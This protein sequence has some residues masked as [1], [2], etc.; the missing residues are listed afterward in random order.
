MLLVVHAGDAFGEPGARRA[1]GGGRRRGSSAGDLAV[2]EEILAPDMVFRGPSYMG[3]PI[4][5]LEAFA[6]FVRYLRS[7]FPD[8]LFI[9]GHEVAEG[10]W[11]ATS[12]TLRGTHR[13]EYMGLGPTGKA[14]DLPGVD[15]FRVAGG[16]IREVRVFYDTLGLMQQLG[17]APTQQSAPSR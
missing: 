14:I 6:Q 15:L 8:M 5:G 11:V 7:A 12:F 17:V 3:E 10:D 13:G 1:D 2:A 16:R 9:V 4:Q